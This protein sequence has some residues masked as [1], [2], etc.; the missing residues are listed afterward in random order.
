MSFS[1][2]IP[3][4]NAI[5]FIDNL[6]KNIS[7]FLNC[8]NA[9]EI[10]VIV[11]D[12]GSIDGTS[13][14]LENIE[15]IVY[16]KQRN[17][18][19]SSARNY[20]IK[21]AKNDYLIFFDSDDDLNENLFDFFLLSEHTRNINFFNYKIN[22]SIVNDNFSSSVINSI[23]IF[24]MFLE[25]KINLT[26]CSLVAKRD[27][28]I[29]K[30]ILFDEGYT[31]GEDIL[32]IFKILNCN[33]EIFYCS[34]SFFNYRLQVGSAAKSMV[35]HKKTEMLRLF[36]NFKEENRFNSNILNSYD[37]FLFTLYLYLVKSC[38]F[39]GVDNKETADFIVDYSF[40]LRIK[41]NFSKPYYLFFQY[42]FILT[43]KLVYYFVIFARKRV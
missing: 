20:G 30:G 16:Y 6:Q 18:G 3:V 14:I 24:S 22:D 9:I 32:F 4:Y 7:S 28:I 21:L 33:L 38:V 37:F 40:L 35:T 36:I 39:F 25:K 34:K 31:L 19:V 13:E 12:D 2:I 8:K 11:I 42:F 17:K 15:G 27:F 41:N 23:D 10:E 5:S 26:I 29:E 43:N 1:I